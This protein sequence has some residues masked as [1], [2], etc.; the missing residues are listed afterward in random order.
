MAGDKLRFQP[1]APSITSVV[2]EQS[3][4]KIGYP[5]ISLHL[6]YFGR[7]RLVL[8]FDNHLKR[9]TGGFVELWLLRPEWKPMLENISLKACNQ[10]GDILSTC[11]FKARKCVYL[12]VFCCLP[13][14]SPNSSMV[15]DSNGRRI[16]RIA[17]SWPFCHAFPAFA[18][19]L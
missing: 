11:A 10:G 8:F 18:G 2:K 13:F 12:P 3:S 6:L 7:I 16:S 19:S 4:R 1:N 5:L 17:F 14:H 9:G 15:A